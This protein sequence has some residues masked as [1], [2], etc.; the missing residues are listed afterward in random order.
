MSNISQLHE[1]QAKV[2]FARDTRTSGPYL[3]TALKAALDAVNVEYAD[4]GIMTTPQL[5]YIVR[6][7]NTLNSP[8]AFGAPT[9]EGYYEKMAKAFK[10]LMHGRTIKGP[11]T[12]DCANG[13]G[14]PKLRELIKYLPTA[15]E[16]GIDIKV[17]ND[18]VLKP[19]A[20]NFEVS[21][22]YFN[23]RSY[24]D[25]LS[26]VQTM[27]RPSN[28]VLQARTLNLVI[29]AALSMVMQT[30]LFTT[31]PMTRRFSIFSMVI[32]LLLLVPFSLQ[33]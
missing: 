10:T 27:S 28:V 32:A 14:G 7:I 25:L 26:A 8:Y 9:E 17:V 4:H 31:T 21:L 33:T 2:V 20:L 13:V 30:V 6:C 29:D 15:K 3:V 24:A 18:D 22:P 5:H 23:Q 1:R 11:I 19:E 12:V 16:G